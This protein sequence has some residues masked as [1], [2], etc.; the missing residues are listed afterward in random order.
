MKKKRKKMNLHKCIGIL[1]IS[2]YNKSGSQSINQKLNQN[3][4]VSS[5]WKKKMVCIILKNKFLFDISTFIWST[6]TKKKKKKKKRNKRKE[7]CILIIHNMEI[8][9]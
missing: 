6:I 8:N 7:N 2:A 9:T 5:T 1:I 3:L 4:L